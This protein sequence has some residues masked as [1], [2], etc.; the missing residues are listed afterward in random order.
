MRKLVVALSLSTLALG[1]TTAYFARELQRERARKAS[2]ASLA[3]AEIPAAAA[4]PKPVADIVDTPQAAS[5]IVA[6]DGEDPDPW[7]REKR[8][9]AATAD[10]ELAKLLDPAKRSAMLDEMK[11]SSRSFYPQLAQVLQLSAFEYDRLLELLAEQQ[12]TVREKVL[13]CALDPRCNFPGV[14]RA[15]RDSQELEVAA[16]IGADRQQ[17][18][19]KYQQSL[20]ERS[21]V[22]QFRG[23]LPDKDHLSE[24]KSEQLITAIAEEHQRFEAG[25]TQG[26]AS[27]SGFNTGGVSFALSSEEAGAEKR[28]AEATEYL[29]RLRERAS[30]ILTPGQL[31][32]FNEMLDEAFRQVQFHVRP[33]ATPPEE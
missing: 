6:A 28:L 26:G 23:R 2:V 1:V 30:Q 14:D 9:V 18:L 24:A 17:R 22:R 19:E 7:E 11:A 5:Q 15:H 31:T 32:A 8:R 25:I 10:R 16:L 4:L 33:D 29:G 20:N 21:A 3:A 12:L 13:R 27:V